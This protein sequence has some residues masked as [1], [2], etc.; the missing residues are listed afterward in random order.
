MAD[1]DGATLR[2]KE[3]EIMREFPIFFGIFAFDFPSMPVYLSPQ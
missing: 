1:E 3:A 2:L